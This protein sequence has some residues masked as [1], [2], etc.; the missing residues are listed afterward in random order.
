MAWNLW[1][2]G[3]TSFTADM[4]LNSN[5][6]I[7]DNGM[8]V[9]FE[10]PHSGG[11]HSLIENNR[12]V[13]GHHCHKNKIFLYYTFQK[14]NTGMGNLGD[15]IPDFIRTAHANIKAGAFIP[16]DKIEEM[17]KQLKEISEAINKMDSGLCDIVS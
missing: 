9:E 11:W 4:F 6:R 14:Y 13:V 3:R 7:T 16:K 2:K 15:T 12:R 8:G 1:S 5:I 17:K 10:C